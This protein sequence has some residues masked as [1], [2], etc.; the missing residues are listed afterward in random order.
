MRYRY[1]WPIDI[2]GRSQS[3]PPFFPGMESNLGVFGFTRKV[4]VSTASLCDMC[5][6]LTAQ[7][8]RDLRDV[9]QSYRVRNMHCAFPASFLG[10]IPNTPKLFPMPGKKFTWAVLKLWDLC[11]Y[12]CGMT[13]L[14]IIAAIIGL[15]QNI[16]GYAQVFLQVCGYAQV[17]LDVSYCAQVYL[18]V[19]GTRKYFWRY[20]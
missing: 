8:S 13:N 3:W 12:I 5:V 2:E 18:Q 10:K 4:R 16:R 15:M 11:L 19:R 20:A 14:K 17:L 6:F 7:E 1:V 9:H